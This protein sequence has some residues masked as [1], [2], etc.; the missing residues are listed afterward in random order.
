MKTKFAV[1]LA[2]VTLSTAQAAIIFTPEAAGV[3]Q[4]SVVGVLTE[5][6]NVLPTTDLGNYSSIIGNYSTGARIISP[7]AFGGANQ[8]NYAAIGNQSNTNTYS[9][10][11]RAQQS[12]FGLYWQAADALNQIEFFNGAN[13]VGTFTSGEVFGGLSQAYNG[14]PNTGQN[15]SERYAYIN[16]T[17]TNATTFDRVVFNNS[18]FTTGFETDNHSILASKNSII[19]TA[20]DAVPEPA[21]YF[22]TGIACLALGYKRRR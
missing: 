17:A 2:A 5:T 16:F 18:A 9:I 8:S 13:L 10:S 7:D 6:F 1:L 11:F 14:N 4:T 3:Q 15:T 21:T 20:T 19:E 22:L 12:F